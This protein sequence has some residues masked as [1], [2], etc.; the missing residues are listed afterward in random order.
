MAGYLNVKREGGK[1]FKGWNRRWVALEDDFL[2]MYKSPQATKP[3]LVINLR[4]MVS[5]QQI[6]LPKT[7]LFQRKEYCF[8]VTFLNSTL[9][10][11][12]ASNDEKGQWMKRFEQRITDA[13]KRTEVP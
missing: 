11:Q 6:D 7:K 4:D 2:V 9:L 8:Q 12:A 3:L 5:V 10:V 13:P 1:L